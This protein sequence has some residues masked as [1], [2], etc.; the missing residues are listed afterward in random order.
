MLTSSKAEWVLSIFQFMISIISSALWIIEAVALSVKFLYGSFDSL[1]EDETSI[2]AFAKGSTLI[3]TLH[4]V[5][6]SIM[7]ILALIVYKSNPFFRIYSNISW[8]FAAFINFVIVMVL[9]VTSLINKRRHCEVNPN[10][11]NYVNAG[12]FWLGFA[13]FLQVTLTLHVYFSIMLRINAKRRMEKEKLNRINNLSSN[14]SIGPS[15]FKIKI[16]KEYDL[17][18]QTV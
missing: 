16:D 6:L 2:Y 9:I 17:T 13:V 10:C 11:L 18:D 5:L 14:I 7:S 4:F 8:L 3:V 15:L 12:L 1:E